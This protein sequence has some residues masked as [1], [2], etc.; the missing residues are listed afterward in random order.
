MKKLLLALLACLALVSPANAAEPDYSNHLNLLASEL[1][2]SIVGTPDGT[3]TFCKYIDGM[4]T[5][6][7][8]PESKLG[9]AYL[10]DPFDDELLPKAVARMF[11]TDPGKGLQVINFMTQTHTNFCFRIR[12]A[13]LEDC[14]EITLYP[15]EVKKYL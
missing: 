2:Q 3:F 5:L 7:V 4:I 12:R 13:P 6:G 11:R 8:N 14:M 9:K 15:P 1:E 10:A